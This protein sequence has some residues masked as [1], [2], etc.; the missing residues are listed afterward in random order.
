VQQ[1]NYTRMTKLSL[2]G[3]ALALVIF[4]G[5]AAFGQDTNSTANTFT[6][7]FDKTT[8]PLIDFTGSFTPTNQTILSASGFEVPLAFS[9]DL[10]IT[11]D[12][13]GRLRGSSPAILM[14]IGNDD[15]I[16]TSYRAVGSVSGGG[17]RPIRVNLT[18]LLSGFDQPVAGVNA[19]F[20]IVITYHL[21]LDTDN[22]VLT[23]T[24]RGSIRIPGVTTGRINTTVSVPVPGSPDG[25]WSIDLNTLTLNHIG[26]S[27]VITTPAGRTLPGKL[28]GS[29]SRQGLWR[30][31]F[32]GTLDGK[33]SS[34]TI[35]LLPDESG[36]NLQTMRGR[37]LGQTV[38]Q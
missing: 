33:G 31:R 7:T 14:Q 34:A 27:G 35:N 36:P 2:R 8:V 30:V 9:S 23:G 25:T 28:S 32:T 16:V 22:W 38:R 37:I 21:F 5:R 20:R 26:G 15:P 12:G 1:P 13:R 4:L 6:L 11:N 3:A 10:A 18:L 17:T 24:S 19:K 29:V